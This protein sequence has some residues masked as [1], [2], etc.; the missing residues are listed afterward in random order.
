MFLQQLSTRFKDEPLRVQHDG[1][2]LKLVKL[3]ADE[4][5]MV[6]H[7]CV[8]IRKKNRR[9]SLCNCIE[10]MFGWSGLLG[11]EPLAGEGMSLSIH[12]DDLS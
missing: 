1:F 3:A 7:G 5:V 8:S 11:R 12:L 9:L 10:G 2:C 6:G 4:Q